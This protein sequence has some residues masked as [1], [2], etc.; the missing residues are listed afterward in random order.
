M[1][2]SFV[3][4][5]EMHNYKIMLLNCVHSICY[6]LSYR[7]FPQEGIITAWS[8][9]WTGKVDYLL[10]SCTRSCSFC[11]ERM[12]AVDS[13]AG[14]HC[15]L[16]QGKQR[17][18]KLA[19]FVAPNATEGIIHHLATVVYLIYQVMWSLWKTHALPSPGKWLYL[20]FTW[21]Y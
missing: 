10:I 19:D 1:L 16:R 3:Y 14:L 2:L 20:A 5:F 7:H 11:T 12:L 21:P 4:H 18:V 15:F 17:I 6:T 8:H 13:S 9:D